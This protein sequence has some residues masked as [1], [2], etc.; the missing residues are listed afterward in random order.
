MAFFRNTAVNRL[1]LHYAVHALALSSGGV[2]IAAFLLRGGVS[3][4]MVLTALAAIVAGRFTIRPL[5]LGPARRWGLR[6]LVIAGTLLVSLQYPIL[7]QVRGVGWPLVVLCAVSSVG[8]TC[9]WTAYHAY[10]AA[11]GDAGHRG[12]QIGAREAVVA[13]VG[14]AGPIAGGWMLAR[15][16][17]DVAFGATTIVMAASAWPLLRSPNVA[18]AAVAPSAIRVAGPALWL[19]GADGLISAGYYTVWQI[20][21]F[22]A[23]G[24]SFTAFGGAMALAALAGA[25]VGLFLGRL[26]DAGHGLRA[27]WL[28]ASSILAVAALRAVSYGDPALAVL[29]NAAGAFVPA[30]YTPTLMT[31]VYNQAKHSPCA[32]R[33]H[34]AT[35]GGWDIGSAIG[36][37]V[38][39][40]LLW[41][42]APIGFAILAPVSGVVLIFGLLRRYYAGVAAP[43][44]SVAQ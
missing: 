19:F 4:P 34:I 17:P 37:L 26:I 14:V 32:L 12:H 44:A 25:L 38:A 11:L 21:L 9:Y 42:K 22:I 18:V 27:V 10:F 1:N 30:L 8:D 36:C 3:A 6:P 39:A 33:F 28:A 23:L 24:Q 20:A 16:G 2:F 7:A 29:A 5:I 43:P 35:E 40:F 41:A 15:L 13:L 31:A